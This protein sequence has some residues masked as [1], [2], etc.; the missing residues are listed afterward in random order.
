MKATRKRYPQN[1]G[2][3]NKKPASESKISSLL[4]CLAW[5]SRVSEGYREVFD[6]T[7]SARVLKKIS[8]FICCRNEYARLSR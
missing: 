5:L 4:K 6:N 1:E 8:V 3:E 7:C 2:K